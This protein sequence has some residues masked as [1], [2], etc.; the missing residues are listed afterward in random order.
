MIFGNTYC[1]TDKITVKIFK[2]VFV[3]EA[4]GLIVQPL[5][6]LDDNLD[7]LTSDVIQGPGNFPY[8]LCSKKETEE[9]EIE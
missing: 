5:V 4:A 9:T 8:N 6:S 7:E 3:Q 1:N 2:L